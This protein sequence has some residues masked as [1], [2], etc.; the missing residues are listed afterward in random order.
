MNN[1][2]L[3]HKVNVT[4]IRADHMGMCFGVR[5]AIALAKRVVKQRPLTVLGELVHNASVLGDLKQR[6]VRFEDNPQEVE[7]NTVMITAHGASER[8]RDEVRGETL[9]LEDATCPLVHFAHNK[10]RQL[11][12][13]GYHP[14]IIGRHGHVEVRGLTEDLEE[15]DVVLTTEDIDRL[16]FHCRLGVVA[17]TTQPI[18]RVLKLVEY[19]KQKFPDSG[20]K[21][22]DTVCQPTK[23]RQDAAEEL[24]LNSDVVLVIG[25]KNSNN[26]GE[27]AR[28]CRKFCCRVHHVQGPE[29]VSTEWIKDGDI[30]GITAGTSTPDELIN[31]VESKVRSFCH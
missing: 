18:N 15:Y 22:V 12:C 11:V 6:G 17:Q 25:G 9:Q 8:T 28:T 27:L 2:T 30:L 31:S 23:Q 5:D 20:V 26:T 29:D 3:Q 21:F 24:A 19:L 1:N 14:V 16:A 4:I 13:S 10:V 7:T